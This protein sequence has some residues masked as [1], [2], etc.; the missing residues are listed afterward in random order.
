MKFEITYLLLVLL[1]FKVFAQ[2]KNEIN[3]PKGGKD[4]EIKQLTSLY[5]LYITKNQEVYNDDRK[6]DYYQ[7][8]S[9]TFFNQLYKNA[10]IGIPLFM[11]YADVKTP[12]K[13]VSKVKQYIPGHRWV[14]YMTENIEGLTATAFRSY[15]SIKNFVLDEIL[16]LEAENDLLIEEFPFAPPLPPP[17][18]WYVDFE[19][20][21]YSNDREAIQGSLN[22][23]T[24]ALITISQNKKLK[25]ND[26]VLDEVALGELVKKNK[27]L[28][29]D[30]EENVFYEDYIDA[31]QKIKQ[32][33]IDLER[34]GED[35]AY[36]VEVSLNLNNNLKALNI[37]LN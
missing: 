1:S 13:F 27:V 11:L 22:E 29:L 8:I 12:F 34:N 19:E 24:H 16:T 3:L 23:Y 4:I 33:Q 21:L 15:G 2:P 14:F 7:D 35:K 28:F 26:L 32:Y 10:S 9:Y 18:M 6:L 36:V 31:I 30:F 17:S 37:E 25:H 5:S 20:T